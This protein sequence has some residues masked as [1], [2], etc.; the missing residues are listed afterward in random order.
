MMQLTLLLPRQGVG[1]RIARYFYCSGKYEEHSPPTIST[2]G[3]IHTKCK[4]PRHL[5]ASAAE[6]QIAGLFKIVKLLLW[7]ETC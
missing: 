4:L 7:L 5:V 6:T 1:C 2:N 3:P